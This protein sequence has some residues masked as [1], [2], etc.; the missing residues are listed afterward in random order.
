MLLK[1]Q[2]C[3]GIAR[4]P[5][6]VAGESSM[7]LRPLVHS[8]SANWSAQRKIHSD[9]WQTESKN[10]FCGE[11]LSMSSMNRREMSKLTSVTAL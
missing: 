1:H 9:W 5:G 10:S 7:F 6:Q 3:C 8:N 4:T 11:S 2:D